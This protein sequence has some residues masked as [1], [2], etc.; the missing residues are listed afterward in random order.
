M[1]MHY[2]VIDTNVIVSD[3]WNKCRRLLPN[4]KGIIEL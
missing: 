1:T 2:V 4:Q 3:C